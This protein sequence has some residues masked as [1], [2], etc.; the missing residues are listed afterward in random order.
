LAELE[1]MDC[2]LRYRLDGP[3]QDGAKNLVIMRRCVVLHLTDQ[4]E[5]SYFL[6]GERMEH[7]VASNQ[8][9]YVE[10][11][12]REELVSREERFH[13]PTVSRGDLLRHIPVAFHCQVPTTYLSFIEAIR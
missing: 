2:E 13:V 12:G 4:S 7:F 10:R 5:F 11:G 8:L 1:I 9:H 3:E 6:M